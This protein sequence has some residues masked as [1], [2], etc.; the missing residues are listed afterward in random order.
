MYKVLIRPL[1]VSD[2]Q[3]SWKWRNNPKI[4][5][6]TGFKPNIQVTPEVEHDWILK[7]LAD[8]FTKRFAI[9]VDDVYVGNIHFD[10]IIEYDTAKYHIFIGDPSYWGKGIAKLATYQILHYAKH[11]LNL[12]NVFLNVRKENLSAIKVYEKNGFKTVNEKEGWIKMNCDISQLE[13]PMASVFVM[14]YNHEKYI[15]PAILKLHVPDVFPGYYR[16]RTPVND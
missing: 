16:R 4:W 11:V 3:I 6:F 13:T 5:E 2:A 15:L 8:K 10:N 7:V 14:V 1:A 9:L 12:K